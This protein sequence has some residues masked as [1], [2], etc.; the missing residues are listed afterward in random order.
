MELNLVKKGIN[1]LLA[2]AV[3]AGVGTGVAQA[4]PPF[5]NVVLDGKKVGF[6]DAQ[7]FVDANGRTLV[8]VRFVTESLGAGV[9]WLGETQTVAISYQGKDILL[10]IGESKATVNGSEK[11]L[12]TQVILKGNRTFVPLRFVS[13]SLDANVT[14]DGDTSTVGIQ[15]PAAASTTAQLDAYG[16]KIRTTNLPSNY[17]D[18]PY[19]LEDVPNEMYEMKLRSYDSSSQTPVE[20]LASVPEFKDK[21]N[22]DLTMDRIR[23]HYALLLNVDYKTIDPSWADEI[24]QYRN[25]GVGHLGDLQK[26]VQW[27]KD[28]QIEME[29]YVDPEPSMIYNGGHEHLVR[30]KFKLRINHYN[31]YK[32]LIYDRSFPSAHLDKGFW[33]EG[34]TDITVST[35]VFGNWGNSLKVDPFSLMFYNFTIKRQE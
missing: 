13:E 16:R 18:Y 34:V 2:T 26:Y 27:V 11:A 6:P 24:Y 4:A 29:G 15:T 12:D 23:K 35:N 33:Y 19:I 28:N 31:E 14:W 25:Q 1:L 20:L 21:S 30:S 3:L 22:V 8:P 32:N 5:V 10:R 17:K 7:A 9:K